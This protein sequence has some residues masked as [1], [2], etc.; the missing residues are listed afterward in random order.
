MLDQNRARALQRRLGGFDPFFRIDEFFR[1]GA[2]VLGRIGEKRGGERAEPGL[3][4]Y[5]GLG[6][7]L[8]LV[9]QIDVFELR[10]GFGAEHRRLQFRRQFVLTADRVENGGAPVLQL[11]QIAQPLF[12]VAQLGVVERAGRFLAV[13]GDEGHS[14][15]GVQQFDGGD[16]LPLVDLQLLGNTTRNGNHRRLHRGELK[17]GA[18][19]VTPAAASVKIVTRIDSDAPVGNHRR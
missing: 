8:G 13:A 1:A 17:L 14:R 6:A 4:G 19:L 15:A 3:A 11:A 10:L 16:D 7:A 5:G 12:E 2:R 18:M 9:G